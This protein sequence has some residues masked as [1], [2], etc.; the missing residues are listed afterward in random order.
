MEGFAVT[1]TTPALVPASAS[2]LDSY[3]AV[4]LS[5]VARSSL[6]EQQMTALATYVRELGGG[7]IL[8]AG[9]TSYGDDGGYSKTD[10]ERVLPITFDAKRPHRSVAMIVVLDKSGSMGGRILHSRKKP[11]GRRCSC[12]P[13]QTVLASLHLIRNLN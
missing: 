2:L 3:D 5:D 10:I 12:L 13:T 4:V 7:F 9:E 6:S 1:T 8:A 11:L